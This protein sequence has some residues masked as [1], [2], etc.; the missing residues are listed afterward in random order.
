MRCGPG[1]ETTPQRANEGEAVDLAGRVR[2]HHADVRLDF[3]RR[4]VGREVASGGERGASRAA[5]HDVEEHIV[6]TPAHVAGAA[7]A[8]LLELGEE[9]RDHVLNL[10]AEL[11]VDVLEQA[12]Q[13]RIGDK[14]RICHESVCIKLGVNGWTRESPTSRSRARHPRSPV[15]RPWVSQ[16]CCSRP[17]PRAW[18][19]APPPASPSAPIPVP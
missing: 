6:A 1:S 19:P 3:L 2:T 7:S 12:R 11:R 4:G 15:W 16:G 18:W 10:L 9:R 13:L 17:D 14:R 8:T 5:G